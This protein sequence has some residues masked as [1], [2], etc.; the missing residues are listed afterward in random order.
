M[1]ADMT[2]ISLFYF[3]YFVQRVLKN[4]IKTEFVHGGS[5]LKGIC[6]YVPMLKH[7]AMK[8]YDALEVKIQAVLSSVLD[9]GES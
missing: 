1:Q 2:F 7:H 4:L 5:L 9:G 3:L 6:K 8:T